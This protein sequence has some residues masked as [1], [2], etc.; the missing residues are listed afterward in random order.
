MLGASGR[1]A[2]Q[3]RFRQCLPAP[4]WPDP[5]IAATQACSLHAASIAAT[6]PAATQARAPGP[7]LAM[8]H[9]APQASSATIAASTCAVS[10]ATMAGTAPAAMQASA[11]GPVLAVEYPPWQRHLRQGREKVSSVHREKQTGS[12]LPAL[13][14][15]STPAQHTTGLI[16]PR[17]AL[18]PK[19]E[20]ADTGFFCHIFPGPAMAPKQC[21]TAC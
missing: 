20:P 8:L 7:E 14:C 4:G 11:P 19:G 2:R 12:L 16:A 1:P 3:V 15:H 10:A 5:P 17:A 6:S 18:T 21:S 13:T 9:S